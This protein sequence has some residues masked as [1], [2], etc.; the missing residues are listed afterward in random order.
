MSYYLAFFLPSIHSRGLSPPLQFPPPRIIRSC[1]PRSDE[2][3]SRLRLNP[4]KQKRET[5]RQER[6][7]LS[8][9]KKAM[10]IQVPVACVA[11]REKA[12]VELLVQ[13]TSTRRRALLAPSRA[14]FGSG[15]QSLR[16]L[17]VAVSSSLA[18]RTRGRMHLLVA[19]ALELLIEDARCRWERH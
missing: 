11:K 7:H 8:G 6:H 10:L 2:I 9:N 17:G 3:Q 16:F 12:A 15:G 19:L 13:T 1:L 5:Q 18:G 14:G 4:A